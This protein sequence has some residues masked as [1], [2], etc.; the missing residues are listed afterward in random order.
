MDGR[1]FEGPYIV[2]REMFSNML[3]S[4]RVEMDGGRRGDLQELEQHRVVDGWN[5]DSSDR[6]LVVLQGLLVLQAHGCWRYRGC[7]ANIGGRQGMLQHE[8]DKGPS[9]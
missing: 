1:P 5:V 8:H 7:Y 4:S 2:Q 9:G 6:L 3:D